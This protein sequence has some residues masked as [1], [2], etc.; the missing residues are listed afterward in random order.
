MR[1]AA[2]RP[3]GQDF[4]QVQINTVQKKAKKVG[5]GMRNDVNG[6]TFKIL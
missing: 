6:F 2:G 3:G 5:L 1:P 4:T